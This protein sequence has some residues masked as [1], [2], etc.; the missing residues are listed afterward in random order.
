M[1][2][3]DERDEGARRL[4]ETFVSA[5]ARAFLVRSTA[6]LSLLLLALMLA[7]TFVFRGSLRWT[8]LS[9]WLYLGG[10]V[11]VIGSWI[12]LKSALVNWVVR[13]WAGDAASR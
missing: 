12:V 3:L 1:G 11:A 13:R 8:L 10:T 9:P 6:R 5:E 2:D 7:V 4:A